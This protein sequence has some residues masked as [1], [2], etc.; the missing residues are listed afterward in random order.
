MGKCEAD[1]GSVRSSDVDATEDDA[2]AVQ[3][4]EAAG[5]HSESG[6]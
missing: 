4:D 2:C 5:V 6:H 1:A 3:C